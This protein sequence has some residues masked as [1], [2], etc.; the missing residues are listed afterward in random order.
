M[1]GAW[2]D[3]EDGGRG[4]GTDLC[5]ARV[6]A[7]DVLAGQVEPAGGVRIDGRAVVP[8]GAPALPA[9]PAALELPLRLQ[10]HAA[11]VPLGRALVQVHCETGESPSLDSRSQLLNSTNVLLLNLYTLKSLMCSIAVQKHGEITAVF[12]WQVFSKIK[13]TFPQFQQ[14]TIAIYRFL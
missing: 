3:G 6:G 1:E 2:A 9:A 8:Q 14:F 4:A 13:A 10:A 11:A 7:L 5:D 12:P